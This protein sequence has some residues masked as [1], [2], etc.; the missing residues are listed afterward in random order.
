MI[1]LD[2]V[3]AAA[4][5]IEG[6]VAVTPFAPARILSEMSGAT[7]HIKFENYQFTASFKERGALN[8]L[9]TLDAAARARGVCAMS[10]GNHAQAVA[11]HGRRLGVPTLI[12][13]PAITPIVKIQ[14][15]R[16]HGAEVVLAGETLA[17]SQAEAF[18]LAEE[19]QL[20]FIHPYDD[21]LV[22]AGQGTMAIEMLAERPDLDTLV[23]PVGG[24]GL[25]SGIATAAKAIK[26]GVRVVG[27]QTSSYSSIARALRGESLAGEGNTIAE[28]I[29]VKLPGKLTLE[30]IRARVDEMLLVEEPDIER[31]MALYLNVEKTVAEGAGA[32][33][34][35]AVLSYPDTFRG[36]NVGVV[37]SGGNVDPRLL[38]SV[39]VRELVREHRI[40]TI[41]VPIADRPGALAKVTAAVAGAGANIIEVQHHRSLLTLPAKDAALELTFEANDES[42]AAAVIEAVRAAGFAPTVSEPA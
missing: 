26:P 6:Q 9:L 29:A 1:G 2:D 41:R 19:R 39:I 34:L 8:R 31:A 16:A 5:R 37:L 15:T 42:H 33:A 18:R 22:M 38:A 40:V 30:V 3:R 12:V 36:R 17:E 28:G 20:T 23:V 27:V 14:Q 11:Y 13:M 21:P 24:G 7:L 25:I 35:A 32:A 4:R 10:A